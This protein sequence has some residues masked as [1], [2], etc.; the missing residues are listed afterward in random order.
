MATDSEILAILE[1]GTGVDTIKAGCISSLPDMEDIT[2]P[3]W[4]WMANWMGVGTEYP[5][6]GQ[7]RGLLLGEDHLGGAIPR[8]E[9]VYIS[10]AAD[11]GT[12]AD[13]TNGLVMGAHWGH[14]THYSTRDETSKRAVRLQ[15]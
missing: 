4:T 14:L 6:A 12:R 1:R 13:I 9:R 5:I 2:G 10:D 11:Y 3:C 7:G 8:F 15:V